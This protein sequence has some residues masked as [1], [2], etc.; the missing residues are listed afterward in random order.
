MGATPLNSSLTLYCIYLHWRKDVVLA[1]CNARGFSIIAPKNF[2]QVQHVS[3][4]M[5]LMSKRWI[6]LRLGERNATYRTW[7]W[8]CVFWCVVIR[9]VNKRISVIWTKCLITPR[10]TNGKIKHEKLPC[11]RNISLF[12]CTRMGFLGSK[13]CVWNDREPKFRR[14]GPALRRCW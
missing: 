6:R 1:R 11:S 7:Q 10:R 12:V 14:C 8:L 13:T 2:K 5:T 4:G 9:D 3:L